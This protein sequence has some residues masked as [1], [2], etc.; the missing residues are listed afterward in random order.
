MEQ[1]STPSP[2]FKRGVKNL[3]S[4]HRF[5]VACVLAALAFVGLHHAALMTQIVGAWDVFA[6]TTVVLAWFVLSTQDPY[7]VRRNASLQD[8]SQTFLFIVVVSAA[9]ISL[10]AVFIMLGSAKNLSPDSFASHV[11]LSIAAIGLS[12]T[13]VHTLFSLRYA[14][15]YY[16]D[17]HKVNR[18]DIEGGVIFPGDTNPDYL[19]FAY[20]SFVIG[21]T[22]QVSDVQISSKKMRRLATVHGL[23]SFAFNTA[24]LALF[25]NIVAGLI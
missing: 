23:I 21:M 15:F 22:C 9:T 6:F 11:I 10:F 12:W 4:H 5:I 7:E 2:S 24:I 25:V 19:D 1:P 3:D 17:A 13:L 20:F 16:N 8:A 18:E 14:H